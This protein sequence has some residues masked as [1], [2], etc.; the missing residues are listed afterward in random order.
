MWSGVAFALAAGMMWGLVFVGPLL[1]PEYPAALQSYG[2]YLCFGLIALPLGWMDRA[3]LRRLQR[4][5]W[6]EALK[7]AMVGN[8]I[9]YFCLASAIQRAG[10]QLEPLWRSLSF[11]SVHSAAFRKAH[12]TRSSISVA[13]KFSNNFTPK[14]MLSKMD[15][16]KGVGF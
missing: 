15:I 6:L 3:E 14:A 13:F 9:Y 10:T 16:G 1:I 8:L 4:S 11:T 7:L 5:D 2:R 12:S